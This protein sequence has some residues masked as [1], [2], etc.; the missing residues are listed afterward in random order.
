MKAIIDFLLYIKNKLL[1]VIPTAFLKA[2]SGIKRC[3]YLYSVSFS[4]IY[5]QYPLKL[6]QI[7]TQEGEGYAVLS[8]RGNRA[9][10]RMPVKKLATNSQLIQKPH[11]I[12]KYFE[13]LSGR[14][15]LPIRWPD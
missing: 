11:P 12:E 3:F 6:T 4:K 8:I 2:K 7:Y 10:L 9:I 13:T 14:I 5:T 15:I 1:D